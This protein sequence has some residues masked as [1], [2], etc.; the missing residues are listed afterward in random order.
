[1]ATLEEIRAKDASLSIPLYVGRAGTV[2][3][4]EG[5]EAHS[6]LARALAEW[7]DSS[8]QLRRALAT[9]LDN[10]DREWGWGRGLV[11][12]RKAHTLF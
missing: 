12:V 7:L 2:V 4:K 5:R 9:V 6:D 3:E 1:V 8:R 11:F 10:M